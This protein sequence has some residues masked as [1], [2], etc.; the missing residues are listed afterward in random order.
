M[1][2][3]PCDVTVTVSTEM[4]LLNVFSFR[5]AEQQSAKLSKLFIAYVANRFD[6]LALNQQVLEFISCYS[7]TYIYGLNQ[8]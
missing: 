4:K 7:E 2:E 1:L 5:R 6:G 3:P 8:E